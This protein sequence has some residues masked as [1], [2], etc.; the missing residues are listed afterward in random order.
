MSRRRG[1]LFS[2]LS[3]KY[4]ILGFAFYF[5]FS[6]SFISITIFFTENILSK[7]I[8]DSFIFVVDSEIYSFGLL[9][10]DEPSKN[11]TLS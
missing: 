5:S 7:N 9:F 4:L 2:S 3:S 11:L 10:A 6:C 1:S 8:C